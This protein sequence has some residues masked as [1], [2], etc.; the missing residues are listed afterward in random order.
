MTEIKRKS[1]KATKAAAFVLPTDAELAA[2]KEASTTR[3]HQEKTGQPGTVIGIDAETYA[4]AI[5]DLKISPMKQDYFRERWT[6]KGYV[7]VE[8][9]PTVVG[10]DKAEVWIKRRADLEVDREKRRALIEQKVADG[11]MHRSALGGRQFVQREIPRRSV[12][13]I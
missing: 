7:K 10:F 8:G 12:D 2:A 1:K 13:I 9:S 3:R 11:Q 4:C 5:L 6:L